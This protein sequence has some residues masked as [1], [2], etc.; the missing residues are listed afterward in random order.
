[1]SGRLVDSAVLGRVLRGRYD[2]VEKIGEG[3]FGSVY[4]ARQLTTGQTVAIKVLRMPTDQPQQQVDRLLARFQREMTLCTQLHHP[5]IVRIID[6]AQADEGVVYT[7]F[8]F[9]PGKNLAAIIADERRVKPAEARHLMIQV[10]DALACAHRQGVIHRDLKPANIMVV[11]T[12]ARRNAVVLDFGVGAL[13]EEPHRKDGR[14]T[15]SGEWIGTP[16]Y[17]APEHLRG[18]RITPRSDLYSWGAVFLECLTGEWLPA[19]A[20]LPSAIYKH[21]S[22]DP[23]PLPEAITA[24]PVGRVLRRA[25][26]KDPE[27]R[28][29]TAEGLLRDLE[30]CDMSTLRLP[31][32]PV[33]SPQAAPPAAPL[34][35]TA[36]AGGEGRVSQSVRQT[37]GERRQITALCCAL[38]VV[39]D[40]PMAADIEELDEILGEEQDACSAVAS[41][42]GGHVGGMLSNTMLFFFGYPM[43]RE[44]D[45]RRAARAA[46]N[47]LADMRARNEKT[48]AKHRA[49][50]DI[51]IG[52]H[53]GMMVTRDPG[54]QSERGSTHLGGATPQAAARLSTLA[55]P[56][57]ILV[58][59]ETHRLLRGSFV[60][61]GH[62][63]SE[64]GAQREGI[65]LLREGSLESDAA[66]TPLVG[67]EREFEALM[68][69][70]GKVRGG[71]GQ[72]VLITG[73]PGV[74][75]SR[76]T[77]ALQE[78]LRTESYTY[79]EGRCSP[80]AANSPLHPI[81]DMLDRL[82]DPSR[83][84]PARAKAERLSALLSSHGFD[85]D[86]AMPLLAP[87]LSLPL[88][89]RFQTLDLSPQKKRERT[90]NTILSLLFEMGERTPVVLLVEDLQWADPSTLEL[91]VEIVGEVASGRVFAIFTGRP[92]FSPPWSPLAALT[93]PL[94]N[95]DRSDI[96]RLATAIAGH[97]LPKE[98]IDAIINRTDGVPLFVEEFIRM[99][100][101]SG[102]LAE[103]DGRMVLTGDLSGLGI[104]STLRD[105]LMARLDR[106]GRAKDT[107]HAAAVIGREFSF[108]LLQAVL[109]I[110][111]SARRE[112]LDKLV[113][114]DLVHRKRR[115]RNPTYLFKH[116]LIQD[117]AYDSM[118]KTRRRETHE[119]VARALLSRFPEMAEEHPEILAL[120]LEQAGLF[121]E[122]V[123]YLLQSG[124]RDL[125]R[126]AHTEAITSLQRGITL[127]GALP[128]SIS[129]FQRELELRAVLGGALVSVK[130]YCAPDV[131]ENLVRARDLCQRLD[132]PL[133]MFPVLYGLWV[134]NLAASNRAPTEDYAAQLLDFVHV[135]PDRV[136]EI[137]A[138]FAYGNTQL[139]RG[140]FEQG[141]VALS[142]ALSL[143]DVELHP[144][145]VRVY[146][147]DH[148][149]YSLV[150]RAWIEVFT[151]QADQ[152]RA[153]VEAS[154]RLSSRLRNPLATTLAAAFSMIV[155]RDL[156]DVDRAS[157][158]AERTIQISTEQ[159]FPFWR[160]LALCGRGW[161]RSMRGDHS[162]GIAE[163]EE[164]LSFFD[165]IQQKLP[166]TY[167]DA[168]LVEA[169]LRAERFDEGMKVVDAALL[170]AAVNVDSFNEPE[171]LRLK[172]DLV[173][174]KAGSPDAAVAWYDKAVT[175]ARLYGAVYYELRAALSLARA[176]VP[177]GDVERARRTL[178]DA[179]AKM[180]EGRDVPVHDEAARLLHELSG[181]G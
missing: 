117:T 135:H 166:R 51:R 158:F 100:L 99:M 124:Q 94:G 120:H 171:L 127:L 160:S 79:L 66:E 149:M 71:M 22:P 153:S 19:G 123:V 17:A 131:T 143:Y 2:L 65:A 77:R 92:E 6:S 68:E 145:L 152:A 83:E 80:D 157:E 61:D 114:A 174:A 142:R 169:L 108:D 101:E 136:R 138:Y 59:G 132:D 39:G 180:V 147:D 5:N 88:P 177:L 45:A 29:V 24:H 164:G 76:L 54:M 73:E 14:I 1:M 119:R 112:D 161:V 44:D 86:E 137:T 91:C 63:P 70:W 122:A 49:H 28:D 72:A 25:L 130:G 89:A 11:P 60:F 154:W 26:E 173:A 82:V 31:Y 35:Q 98:V 104:P 12:G 103:R 69:R 144:G 96:D 156:R 46:L 178:A 141:R 47:M 113:A 10:L 107:A 95:L 97:A 67:R 106:L 146:G 85:L 168:Y 148:G 7:V 18:E 34:A 55:Q 13:I 133:S 50:V 110:D 165:L 93:I 20:G 84:L 111:E 102:A 30:A 170:C 33:S 150:Y 16:V 172:G 125:A 37:D 159:A 105:L 23:I 163:I 116:A 38:T 48:R 139:Y 75:K 134:T 181:M 62:S 42:F 129:R 53:T 3:G 57:E 58:S 40:G 126:G 64:G 155:Y 81:V 32:A 118:L 78:R 15:A 52:L 21:L 90:R 115:N 56:G 87:L 140:R 162:R 36:R 176:L 74:G 109:P 179:A 41:R 175:M 27:A 8:E 151:G 167:W 121:D 43:A 4:K 9:I 128:D